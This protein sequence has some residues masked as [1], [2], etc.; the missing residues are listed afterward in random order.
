MHYVVKQGREAGSNQPMVTRYYRRKKKRTE[1]NQ[2]KPALVSLC[3]V[4][5]T[6]GHINV[7]KYS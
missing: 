6:L 5:G 3:K 4:N 2:A 1:E 7:N